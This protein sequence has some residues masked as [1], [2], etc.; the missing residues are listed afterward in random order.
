M[1]GIAPTLDGAKV[2]ACAQLTF[3]GNPAMLMKLLTHWVQA[4][5]RRTANALETELAQGPDGVKERVDAHTMRTTATLT[6]QSMA[7]EST[8]AVMTATV[9]ES[10]PALPLAG[11]KE[12]VDASSQLTIALLMKA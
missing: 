2:R 10:E 4:S 3:L 8:D 11:A 6:R 5:A 12:S 9:L 1:K 7:L